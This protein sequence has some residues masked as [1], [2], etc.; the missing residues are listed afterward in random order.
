LSISSDLNQM[1]QTK[2]E[3]IETDSMMPEEFEHLDI[4]NFRL[5]LNAPYLPTQNKTSNK[6]YD[7]FKEQVKKAF[8]CK[9]AKDQVTFFHFLRGHAHPMRLET[10]YFGKFAKFTETLGNN[11]PLSNCTRL[12]QCVQGHLNYHLGLTS[13]VINRI[14]NLDATERLQN[15]ANG[16]TLNQVTLREKLYQFNLRM[17]LLYFY[18]SPKG[19]QERLRPL[20]QTC[21]RPNRRQR[22]STDK[23]L[24][25]VSTTGLNQIP[26]SSP[27]TPN[28]PI[29][30]S[31]R[32]SYTRSECALGI[33][34]HKH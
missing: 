12:C 27:S 5:K 2:Y 4:T 11:N 16:T 1:L 15:S 7:H 25:G 33:Q 6:D 9:L 3:N 30:L 28:L 17:G 31:A 26:G 8:H 23:L 14:D 13:L 20:F 22:R 32:Y 24:L 21:R 19:P 29:K 34:H 18:S 10:K